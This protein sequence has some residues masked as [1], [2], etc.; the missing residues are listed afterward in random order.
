MFVMFIYI[1]SRH[2]LSSAQSKGAEMT[3]WLS[4]FD[5]VVDLAYP[6]Y[7]MGAVQRP[8][9]RWQESLFLESSLKKYLWSSTH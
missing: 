4:T 5:V 6:L 8:S 3:F 1:K 7:A 9:H 2:K